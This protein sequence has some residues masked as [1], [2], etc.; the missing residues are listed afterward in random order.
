MYTNYTKSD[1]KIPNKKSPKAVLNN[2]QKKKK[3][4]KNAFCF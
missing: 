2:P 3:N 1:T 4:T